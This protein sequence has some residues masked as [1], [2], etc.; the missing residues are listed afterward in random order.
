MKRFTPWAI[1]LVSV[2]LAGAGGPV[3]P[4][5]V[6][7]DGTAVGFPAGSAARDARCVQ[8]ATGC[9]PRPWWCPDDYRPKPCPCVCRSC[10]CGCCDDYCAKPAPCVCPPL[11]CGCCDDYCPKPAPCVRWPCAWPAWFKCP[12]PLPCGR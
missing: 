9:T 5:A 8:A 10:P 6:L 7:A 12:P 2:A 4:G 1:A 3:E 11:A